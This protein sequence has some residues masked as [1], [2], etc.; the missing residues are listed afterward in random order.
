[1]ADTAA[2]LAKDYEDVWP[3][4]GSRPDRIDA[5]AIDAIDFSVFDRIDTDKIA[6]VEQGLEDRLIESV[7]D[8]CLTRLGA[9]LDIR[10]KAHA[11]QIAQI[12][13]AAKSKGID[14]GGGPRH[15]KI[16]F[17]EIKRFSALDGH[18]MRYD[19]RFVFLK[20][21]FDQ[22]FA[23]AYARAKIA[24]KGLKE[25]YDILGM[26]LPLATE[27]GYLNSLTLWAQRA[28]DALDKELNRRIIASV[29]MAMSATVSHKGNKTSQIFSNSFFKERLK[30]GDIKFNFNGK[31]IESRS[32]QR[33]LLREV[34]FEVVLDG[35]Q[36]LWHANV[37]VKA[38]SGRSAS[39]PVI[40]ANGGI[41]IAERYALKSEVHNIDPLGEWQL[42]FPNS[43]INGEVG[44]APGNIIIH[45]KLSARDK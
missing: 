2:S 10:E 6:V 34:F 25:F 36:R 22:N 40:A 42:L 15:D 4:F 44:A 43:P 39:A 31:Y 14:M 24:A 29:P 32:G 37:H 19:Q 26:E 45:L 3:F 33:P 9:C 16:Y 17:D 20:E 1:M 23:E 41:E 11:L 5:S 28:S 27:Y 7:L 21:M 12:H 13:N 18:G 35:D 38:P 30:A 8:N